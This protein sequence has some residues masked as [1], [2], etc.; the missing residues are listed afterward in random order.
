MTAMRRTTVPIDKEGVLLKKKSI[1]AKQPSSRNQA[2]LGVN[3]NYCSS[4]SSSFPC[5]VKKAALTV[6]P[7]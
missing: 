1:R 7:G 2:A 3:L 5:A 6:C 4:T